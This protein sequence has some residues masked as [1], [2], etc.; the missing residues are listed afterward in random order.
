MLDPK[1]LKDDP[2]G[3]ADGLK[4]RGYLLD[5]DHFQKLEQQKRKLQAETQQ[6]QQQRNQ[7]SKKIGKFKA[8]QQPV[9]E[10][11]T[12]VNAIND[13]LKQKEDQ[14]KR[15]Q[16]TLHDWLLQMPNLPASDVPSG[17]DET[18]NVE[19]K[20]WGDDYIAQQQITMSDHVTI[21]EKHQGSDFQAAG[22]I[23]GSRFAVM[24]GQFARLHRALIQF[25]LDTHITQHHYTETYVP[26]LVNES[27]LYGTG[28]LPKFSEDLFHLQGD[29]PYT[30]IPTAEVSLT[31]LFRNDILSEDRLP[32]RLVAHTP[33]F[34]S[35]A[36]SYGKDTRG[37]IRQ[38]QFEKVELVHIAHPDEGEKELELL[39][40][41]AEAILQKLELPYRRVNLSTGDMGFS[42]KKTYDL[43]VWL[44]S[45]KKYRE[46]SSCSWC[47]DFQARRMQ[48]KYKR[49]QQKGS[50]YVHTLNGSG[51]AAGRAWVAIVENN[52]K[53]DG[54]VVIPAVLRDYMGGATVIK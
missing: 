17:E 25:M 22:K 49:Y 30:L 28:Q 51:V 21:S 23:A 45:Q 14:L 44:P 9:D 5:I 20:R 13:Q 36:G 52:Q 29:Y 27:S 33:C 37:L 6:L 16:Q 8:N 1:L 7:L 43:E 41:N 19:M 18:A 32:V 54:S 42:A 50:N 46:I 10:I 38:H 4:S 40:A 24:Y 12:Q 35:E 11:V 15:I 26:Y 47:G 31:N 34:R 48:A 2:V 3:V 53:P 39:T